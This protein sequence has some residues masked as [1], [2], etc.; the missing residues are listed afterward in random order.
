M[1]NPH[2]KTCAQLEKPFSDLFKPVLRKGNPIREI[3]LAADKIAKDA[4][5]PVIRLHLGNPATEQFAETKQA[6]VASVMTRPGGYGPHPGTT[7]EKARLAEFFNDAE[8]VPGH[9]SGDDAVFFPGAT[10]ITKAII[11][12]L[13][14]TR[15]MS[16]CFQN[17]VIPFMKIKHTPRIA[18]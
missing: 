14:K 10:L 13:I 4:N 1:S 15:I 12:L 17:Q 18:W 11:H 6:M 7:E 5:V 9:F 8:N 3:G 16:F 2:P